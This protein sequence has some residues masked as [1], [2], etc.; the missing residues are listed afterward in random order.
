MSDGILAAIIAAAATVFA[1]FVQ[2]RTSTGKHFGVQAA[3]ASSRR[4]NR[5]PLLMLALMVLGAVVG[6]FA[7]AEWLHEGERSAH[8]ALERDLNARIADISRTNGELEHVRAA[9]H[10]E[11]EAEVLKRLGDDGVAVLAT[12]APCTPTHAAA[13][14]A[15]PV[16]AVTSTVPAAQPPAGAGCTEADAA[17][18]TLCATIPAAAKTTSVDLYVRD[19]A[20]TG[21]AWTAASAGH[22]AGE[23]RFADKPVESPEDS[24]SRQ[25]C[26]GFVQWSDR[27]RVARMIVHYA[28]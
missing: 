26:E 3:A 20:D 19:A 6:G 17:P 27:A 8:A 5:L 22:E 16:A 10:A 1:S 24:S 13:T 15:A 14:P 23:A 9:T 4:R 28:L 21:S 12:V 2:L 18:F 11:L 7:F 25:V